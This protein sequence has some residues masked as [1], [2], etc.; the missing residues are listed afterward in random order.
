MGGTAMTRSRWVVVTGSLVA[1]LV[2]GL[3][4]NR[5]LAAYQVY[6]ARGALLA[7]EP[8]A[9]LEWLRAAEMRQP[10]RADIPYLLATAHRRAGQLGAVLS[11]LQ[12]A[13][14]LGWPKKDLKRQRMMMLFE[15]GNVRDAEPYLQKQLAQGCSDGTAE[16]VYE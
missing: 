16:E 13:D 11:H 7:A 1:A 4:W 8:E 15:T 9:A 3:A 5:G 14:E 12:R 2:A 10:D 6:R